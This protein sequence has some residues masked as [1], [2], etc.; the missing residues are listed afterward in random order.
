M[1]APK[2]A[3]SGLAAEELAGRQSCLGHERLGAATRLVRP[4]DV[5]VRLPEVPGDR[6]D[7][8]VGNLRAAG[9]VE[10]GQRLA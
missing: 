4:A 10:E 7:D 8:L 9:P 3:S 6:V 2:I 5:R 1:F